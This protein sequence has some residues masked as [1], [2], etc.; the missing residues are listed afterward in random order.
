M[1]E[2]ILIVEIDCKA[3]TEN[4]KTRDM[5]EGLKTIIKT[6]TA[7]IIIEIVT[8]T[9]ISI[10]TKTDIRMTAMA[11][12]VGLKERD[13][14]YVKDEIF[15]SEIERVHKILQTM[16]PE[17]GM[18]IGFILTFSKNPDKILDSIHSPSRCRSPNIKKNRVCQNSEG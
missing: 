16:S 13:Y 12:L 3:I 9:K 2:I 1:T 17:K 7:R 6:G 15:Q 14:L 4:L 10:K 8:K 11:R 5:K 18:A